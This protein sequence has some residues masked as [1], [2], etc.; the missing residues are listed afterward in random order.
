MTGSRTRIERIRELAH[1]AA[2]TERDLQD[3]VTAAR[4]DG[5]TWQEIADALGMTR[6]AA[7]ERFSCVRARGLRERESDEQPPPP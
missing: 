7:W 2:R 4:Q 1:R 3:A 6:Q 5:V